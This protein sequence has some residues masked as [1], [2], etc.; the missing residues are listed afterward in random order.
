MY[1][2]VCFLFLF[3]FANKSIAQEKKWI[4]S[5]LNNNIIKQPV[6]KQPELSVTSKLLK[7]DFGKAVLLDTTG[8]YLIQ[9]TDILSVDLVFTDYPQTN[10]LRELNRKR[11]E[12]LIKCLPALIKQKYIQVRIIRQMDGYDQATATNMLHGFVINYR[13]IPNKK[14]QERE[15][16]FIKRVSFYTPKTTT[17]KKDEIFTDEPITKETNSHSVA[18]TRKSPY[19]R[20]YKKRTIKTITPNRKRLDAVVEIGDTVVAITKTNIEWKTKLS[21]QERRLYYKYDTLFMVL[22]PLLD[23]PDIIEEPFLEITKET[24]FKKPDSSV[25]KIFKRNQFN[26]LAIVADV[27]ASMHQYNAQVLEWIATYSQQK[28]I[29]YITCFNDGDEKI[30][31]EKII[32]NAGG[33]YGNTFNTF[34]QAA[35]LLQ[36]TMQKGNGGDRPENN[37]EALLYTSL[38]CTDCNEIVMIADAW[39]PVRDIELA[40][41]ISKKVRV[42][43]CGES[44]LHPD[45]ITIALLSGGSLHFGDIDIQSLEDLRTGKLLQLNG[46]SYKFNGKQVVE[47]MR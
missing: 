23:E 35:T 20:A 12:E 36:T 1:R 31:N 44:Y 16:D 29:R 2:I 8:L 26:Q 47:V 22:Y 45:Y 33:I 10:T 27:T 14:E 30:T 5:V 6:Y 15:I 43:A 21:E 41:K 11:F 46:Y 24:I 18:K 25:L 39:A 4:D 38:A 17:T 37:C 32:G 9:N 34:Q 40:N 19:L 3:V 13:V 7:M 28:K 42:I